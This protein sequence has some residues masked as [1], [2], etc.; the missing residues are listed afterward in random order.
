MATTK[1]RQARNAIVTRH[2]ALVQRI[3]R[4]IHGRLPQS[5]ELDDLVSVGVVGLIESI[6]R[7]NPARGVPFDTYARHRIR[8]AILDA[9]R[10][11]D[12]VP[13]SVRRKAQAIEHARKALRTQFGR[14]PTDKEIA[15]RLEIELPDY[16][17]LVRDSEIRQLLSLDAPAANDNPTPLVEQVASDVD[18]ESATGESQL[19]DLVVEAVRHLPERE[20]TAITLYYFHEL[21]LKAV[22]KH[23]GVTESRACQLC[24]QGVKRLKRKLSHLAS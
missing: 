6:A 1:A 20:A 8:G 5:V 22:G 15:A 10:A 7:F 23:L 3:A 13:H 4:Q 2:Y 12:W 19:R 17:N 24:G 9:L 11:V 18:V 14:T 16:R 21:P